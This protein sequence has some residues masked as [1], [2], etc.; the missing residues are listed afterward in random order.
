MT[1]LEVGTHTEIEQILVN[2]KIRQAVEINDIDVYFKNLFVYY[3]ATLLSP[4][5]YML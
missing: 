4:P 3:I 1:L 2:N 5:S